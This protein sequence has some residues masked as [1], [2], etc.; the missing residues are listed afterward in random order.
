MY[1]NHFQDAI[2]TSYVPLSF[3][4]KPEANL[5]MLPPE[6]GALA[7]VSVSGVEA[8]NAVLPV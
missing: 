5:D 8:L 6:W 1:C 3:V 2:I 4:K 7:V